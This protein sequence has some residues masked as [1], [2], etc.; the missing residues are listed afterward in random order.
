MHIIAQEFE[1]IWFIIFKSRICDYLTPTIGNLTPY[2]DH[3]PKITYTCI[4]NCHHNMNHH[5][6]NW[7]LYFYSCPTVLE[8]VTNSIL[9]NNK[10]NVF[11]LICNYMHNSGNFFEQ[12][13]FDELI[14]KM[15]VAQIIE[16]ETITIWNIWNHFVEA[17]F[18]W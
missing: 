1:T 14:W 15:V 18:S 7:I 3:F 6:S 4:K 12:N 5:C 10:S 8:I 16:V 13:I 17:L 9:E 2:Q 11:K